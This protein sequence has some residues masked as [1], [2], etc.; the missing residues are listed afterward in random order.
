MQ[1]K[2]SWHIGMSAG[3]GGWIKTVWATIEVDESKYSLVPE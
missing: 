2:E 1:P 3:G